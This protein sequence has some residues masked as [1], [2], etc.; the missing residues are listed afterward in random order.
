MQRKTTSLKFFREKYGSAVKNFK[1]TI[2]DSS[3]YH[4]IFEGDEYVYDIDYG[5][6]FTNVLI[7]RFIKLY[8][9]NM[10]SFL[11]VNQLVGK[12]Q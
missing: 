5:D 7:S 8:I 1:R 2:L 6:G 4:V 10:C 3:L 11:Y 9:L 12:Q